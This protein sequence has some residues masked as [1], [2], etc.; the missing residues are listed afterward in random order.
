MRII[1][2]KDGLPKR[3]NFKLI[4][5]YN[6]FMATGSKVAKIDIDPDDYKSIDSAYK[7]V[8]SSLARTDF[9]IKLRRVN[10]DLYLIRTD[11]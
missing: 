1:I 2:V 7:S 3:E 9:P 6:E 11:L 5:L 4:N 8:W 10:N